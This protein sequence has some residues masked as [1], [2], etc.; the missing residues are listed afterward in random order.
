MQRLVKIGQRVQ[1]PAEGDRLFRGLAVGQFFTIES[2]RLQHVLDIRFCRR[3]VGRQ[4]LG[5]P[6]LLFQGLDLVPLVPSATITS[7]VSM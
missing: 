3:G 7:G 5:G 4:V 1:Q 6:R 2:D